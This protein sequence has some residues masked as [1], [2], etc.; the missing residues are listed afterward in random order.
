MPPDDG[1]IPPPCST[2]GVG[3]T[4]CDNAPQ[5]KGRSGGRSRPLTQRLVARAFVLGL[6]AQLSTADQA[7]HLVRLAVADPTALHLAVR[8]IETGPDSTSPLAVHAITAL[9]VAA[10]IVSTRPW[11]LARPDAVT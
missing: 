4:T 10:H 11:V 1:P 9:K 7:E 2:L 5:Q 8:C 6:D 3:V